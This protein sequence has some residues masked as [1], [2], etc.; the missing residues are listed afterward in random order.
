MTT[1][2]LIVNFGTT[3]TESCRGVFLE[4]PSVSVVGGDDIII[5]LVG[6]SAGVL[7]PYALYQGTSSL[8]AGV[9]SVV[10]SDHGSLQE[11][12]LDFAESASCQVEY[13]IESISDITCTS[14]LCYIEDGIIK[15]LCSSGSSAK[16]FMVKSGHSCI[17]S[18]NGKELFGAAKAVYVPSPYVKEWAWTVP[19][20]DG[21]LYWFFL[22]NNGILKN[23][24]SITVP[25]LT[26]G[27]PELRNI[28]FNLYTRG[29]ETPIASASIW[30]DDVFIG[31]T[32]AQG[33]LALNGI[34]TGSHTFKATAEGLTDTDL[35]DLNNDTF[36]VY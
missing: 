15:T 29:S 5:R 27:A 23:K 13:P 30:V 2:T 35:D 36:V 26:S 6:Y 11:E 8:G 25:A 7:T 10:E 9:E 21:G 4:I 17:A 32:D 20:G 3:G 24:F 22:Y 34:Y 33:S 28:R 12:T 14:E 31:T 1:S 16:S 19:V 18:K